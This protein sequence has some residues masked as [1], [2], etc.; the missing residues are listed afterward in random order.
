MRSYH[1]MVITFHGSL[2][3]KQDKAMHRFYV[4]S[5]LPSMQYRLCVVTL[6]VIGDTAWNPRSEFVMR[7][8]QEIIVVFVS[9]L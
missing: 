1:L 8:G 2:S 4:F 3:K 7:N 9:W 6:K 5:L